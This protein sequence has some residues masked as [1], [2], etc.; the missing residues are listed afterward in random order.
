QFAAVLRKGWCCNLRFMPADEAD[1][2]SRPP[3]SRGQAALSSNKPRAR[4]PTVAPALAAASAEAE[5]AGQTVR[6]AVPRAPYR[7]EPRQAGQHLRATAQSV[8]I[9]RNAPQAAAE[10]WPGGAI[11]LR[12]GA[13]VIE[14][15]RRRRLA[16]SD[17]GRE[18]GPYGRVTIAR[19]HRRSAGQP[20]SRSLA[21]SSRS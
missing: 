10:R 15:S 7:P 1:G 17:K 18:G 14:D 5:R 16:W 9:G 21:R 6:N 11:T 20:P 8:Q 4:S 12:Q 13:R 19:F 2:G 3:D